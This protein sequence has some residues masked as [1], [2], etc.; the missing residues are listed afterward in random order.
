MKNLKLLLGKILY[1][2]LFL[3]LVP[4]LLFFWAKNTEHVVNYPAIKSISLGSIICIFGILLISWGMISLIK[5]GDGLPMNAFPPSKF[6]KQGPYLFISN[7]IYVGFILLMIGFF[8]AI[9][10]AS[11]LWLVTPITTLGIIAL[12]LGYENISLKKRFPNEKMTTHLDIPNKGSGNAHLREKISSF[13]LAISLFLIGN[14]IIIFLVGGTKPLFENSWNLDFKIATLQEFY[15]GFLFV[16]SVPFI[17]KSRNLLREWVIMVI[18]ATILSVYIALL[19][20]SIG[21]QYLS[22]NLEASNIY[23]TLKLISINIPFYLTL[24]SLK[25]YKKQFNKFALIFYLM[26]FLIGSIQ[27]INSKSLILNLLSSLIIFFIVSNYLK[28]W[29]FFR[30]HSNRIANSWKE[31]VFGSIRIINHG[32]YVGFGSFIGILIAGVLAGKLFAWAIL[33]FA[34]A[35][36]LF[37]AIW[38]QIIEGS[39]KLKRPYGY[40]G[41]LV[42]IFFASFIVWLMGINVWVIIGVISVIM[43]WVQAIGRL[44]CLVNGCCHG[45]PV[46]NP[47]IGI[48]YT[49][50]RSR[51]CGVSGL[52]GKLLHPTPLYAMLWL[53]FIGFILLSLWLNNYSYSFIFGMYLILTGLGRFVEEAYRGEI[54]TVI[55]NGLRLYQWTAISSILIGIGITMIHTEIII[56]DPGFNFEILLSAFIGGLITFI[57]MGVDFPNSN[58]RFSRLV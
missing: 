41:G 39:E 9:G 19:L 56:L 4:L 7:P 52:K 50:F 13:I 21:A 16:F 12:I 37:S 18:I 23:E 25:T 30:Y 51:V 29:I 10:S 6:V 36:I 46:K 27:L 44:R 3:V 5:F 35:V 42:G 48:R 22:I 45:S 43:P 53:F 34:I 47:T 54:Q 8:I 1:A 26:A 28:I 20:P 32:F 58:A 33:A 11:G 40:Y 38:A 15:L 57:A 55:W 14:F 2:L 24:V 17:V 31:W 49:H